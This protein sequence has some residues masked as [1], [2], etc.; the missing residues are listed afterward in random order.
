VRLVERLGHRLDV[1]GVVMAFWA[2]AYSASARAMRGITADL[3]D[4][5]ARLRTVGDMGERT[6]ETLERTERVLAERLPVPVSSAPSGIYEPARPPLE[7]PRHGVI[8]Y[9]CPQRSSPRAAA[10]IVSSIAVWDHGGRC[11]RRAPTHRDPARVL[12]RMLWAT[13]D[14]ADPYS[15]T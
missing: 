4:I 13:I 9:P 1:V 8:P 11:A 3:D 15:I 5:D 12:P 10:F 7:S 2:A 14:D 6:V